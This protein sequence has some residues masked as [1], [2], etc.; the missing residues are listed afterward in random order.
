ML[1]ETVDFC[2]RVKLR[3]SLTMNSDYIRQRRHVLH[4][5]LL[6]LLNCV[7]RENIVTTL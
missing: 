5:L 2:H 1:A 7:S 4:V 6:L 3:M